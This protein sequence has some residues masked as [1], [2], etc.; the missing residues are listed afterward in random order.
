MTLFG[1]DRLLAEPELRRPLEGRRVALLAHPASVTQGPHPQSRCAG[2]KRAQGLGGVRA[3]AW[4]PRRPPGQYDG[5]AGLHR[6]D[7]RRARIQPLRRGPPPDRPVDGHLRHH[8]RRPAGP[9]LP[10]LHLCDDASLRARSGRPARQERLGTRPPEPGGPARGRPDS[11][12]R[13]GKLRRR[14]ADADAARPDARRA[15]PLVHPTTS[16]STS[17]IA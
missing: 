14:R 13:L 17:I 16:T 11:A 10:H 6:S 4:R 15:W 1:I 9:R 12:S 3:A 7:L 8:S 5:V 2:R